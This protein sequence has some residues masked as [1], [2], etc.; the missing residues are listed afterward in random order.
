MD[1]RGEVH[2]YLTDRELTRAVVAKWWGTI[3]AA[4]RDVS[5]REFR[6]MAEFMYRAN[7]EER[8]AIEDAKAGYPRGKPK[9][10]DTILG[11]KPEDRW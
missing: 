6:K 11:E 7:K 2:G 1:G 4:L 5:V 10:G 9:P 8:E 3:P